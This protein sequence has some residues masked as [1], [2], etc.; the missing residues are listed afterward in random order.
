MSYRE[1]MAKVDTAWLRM[2]GPSNLMMITG[3][4]VL[5][6]QVKFNQFEKAIADRFLAFPRFRQ[7]A[8]STARGY[9]W[10]YDQS[11][12]LS[13]HI[14]HAALPGR[15]D[16]QALQKFVSELA[17]T[18]LDQ[19]KP[20]WQFHLVDNYVDGP[21]VIGRIHH[22]Y[23]DGMALVQVMF[24]LTDVT[25]EGSLAEIE[26]VAWRQSRSSESSL[27]QR[28]IS[29][30]QRGIHAAQTLG[31]RL[32]KEGMGI[33]QDP[34]LLGNQAQLVREL[35]DELASLLLIEDDP[36]SRLKGPLGVRK[37]VAW[38][39][40]VPLEEVKAIGYALG[41]TVNDVLIGVMTGALHRYLAKL[42]D[43]P[44][45]MTMRATVPVNLRPLEHAKNLGNHFGLV[46]LDLPIDA[47]NPLARIYRV[48]QAMDELKSSKQAAVSLG[49]LAALGMAPSK[50]QAPALELFSDKATTV[51]TNVPGP[52]IPLYLAGVPIHELMFWVPQNGSIGMGISL[53]SYAGQVFSG[54]I[55]DQ[56]LIADPS[57][58]MRF[59]EAEF[60]DLLYLALLVGPTIHEL[61]GD[62]IERLHEWIDG[63]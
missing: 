47:G 32:L 48:S 18:P 16:K 59:F 61:N 9:F 49:L 26:P 63:F 11:F 25:A 10:E 14:R 15:A 39:N 21:V 1:P 23:A 2:E 28:L 57:D 45:G 46:F 4:M 55:A 20:L 53:M 13:A 54:L 43:D 58:V 38:A 7:K 42:G 41:C 8:V 51:L 37:N 19:T 24:S 17:S 36:P 29:P 40:P 52:Q 31:E 5:G 22:C 56:N 35:A 62:D 3:V 6:D 60:Q 34:S 33:V 27:F 44:S 12:E 50:I 30:A